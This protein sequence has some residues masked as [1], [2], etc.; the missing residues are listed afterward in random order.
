MTE[1]E[2]LSADLTGSS[3]LLARYESE[4]ASIDQLLERTP[5]QPRVVGAELWER[6]VWL[7]AEL[8]KRGAR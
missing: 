6:R 8:G 3:R 7:I 4:L 2:F 1:R 5:E